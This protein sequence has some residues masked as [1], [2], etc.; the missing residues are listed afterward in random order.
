MWMLGVRSAAALRR[1]VRPGPD[2]THGEERQRDD[3]VHRAR[4]RDALQRRDDV[5]QEVERDVDEDD[6]EEPFDAEHPRPALRQADGERS[7]G[8]EGN[9]ERR[10]RR[11][12]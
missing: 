3:E 5:A 1:D 9:A 12:T 2:E 6:A 10:A 4:P 11:R 7:D 8:E